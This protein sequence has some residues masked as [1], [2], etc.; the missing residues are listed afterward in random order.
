V[1]VPRHVGTSAPTKSAQAP[2]KLPG[3]DPDVL[4]E[5]EE[6]EVVSQ[7]APPAKPRTA[8][9]TQE[10]MDDCIAPFI[11][12][13]QTRPLATGE[14]RPAA[15]TITQY[16]QSLRII[17]NVAESL[18]QERAIGD[19]FHIGFDYR[20]LIMHESVTE[21]IIGRLRL[22]QRGKPLGHGALYKYGL[23]LTDVVKIA[24]SE[25]ERVRGIY[26]AEPADYYK[27]AFLIR[28][29]VE[30]HGKK[31]TFAQR[32]MALFGP[33]IAED[34]VQVQSD[35][36]THAEMKKVRASCL[37]GM[38]SIEGACRGQL[39]PSH[40]LRWQRFF[41]T[42]L[43]IDLIGPRSQ[44]MA[45][46]ST[47]TVHKLSTGHYQVRVSSEQS[48]NGKPVLISVPADLTPR[49]TFLLTRVL[50]AGH[51][52]PLFLTRSGAPRTDFGDCTEAT[53]EAFIG[54]AI[55]PHKFRNSVSTVLN[56]REDVSDA[57]MRSAAAQM[58]HT[59]AVQQAVY[60][61]QRLEDAE[62]IQRMIRGERD[63]IE[64]E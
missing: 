10:A 25:M 44:V 30:S 7:P 23:V 35:I 27:G 52:G 53:T 5:E 61:R 49:M 59:S 13:L 43:F 56:G 64:V 14:L 62:E 42:L 40:K 26:V 4:M 36:M 51:T 8:T 20:Q 12:W 55:S 47:D 15:S 17:M 29:L 9:L 11:H 45:A 46:L 19:I 21:A 63:E 58:C 18:I 57:L 31:R 28:T 38:V 41:V 37:T 3:S 22:G 50:P 32:D 60:V 16:G 2:A 24:K 6:P 39:P 33:A 1:P 54:R 48:K 34:G